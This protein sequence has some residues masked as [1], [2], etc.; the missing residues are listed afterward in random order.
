MNRLI[1][2]AFLFTGCTDVQKYPPLICVDNMLYKNPYEFGGEGNVYVPLNQKC[3]SVN[4]E[5]QK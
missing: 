3:I 5:K 1:V 4:Q 2:I